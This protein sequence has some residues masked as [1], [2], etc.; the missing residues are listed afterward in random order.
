[1]ERGHFQ[2][3]STLLQKGK[4]EGEWDL[5]FRDEM[6]T[7]AVLDEISA[8]EDGNNNRRL[9]EEMENINAE[10]ETDVQ[11]PHNLGTGVCEML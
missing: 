9:Y 7:T 6:H 3:P 2:G 5:K 1:V 8:T 11:E 4:E 10:K